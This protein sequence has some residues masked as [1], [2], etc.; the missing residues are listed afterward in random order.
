MDN[1]NVNSHSSIQIG[2][3]YFDP[4]NIKDKLEPAKYIFLTHTHY[5]HLSIEDIK[6][7]ATTE[8]IFVATPDA[9][10]VLENEYPANQ[11]FY[12]LPNQN[13][14]LD[15]IHIETFASY[16]INKNFH[17]REFDWVGYLVTKNN[18]TYCIVGDSDLTPEL[19]NI[20]CDVLFVPIGGT[21]TMNSLEA[22][23]LT[24]IIH[25]KLVVPTHYNLIVGTKEDEKI[26]LNNISKDIEYRIFL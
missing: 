5:D 6:K 24:N 26:F 2:N 21:Y 19:K 16:N 23:K 4:Y 20:K 17:K 15:E 8:T 18:V 25:P 11:K 12:I 3:I 13:L 1:I 10:Q 7:V 22:S 14:D 9:K